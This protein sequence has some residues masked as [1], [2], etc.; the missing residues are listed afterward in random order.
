MERGGGIHNRA[1][2]EQVEADGLAGA[3]TVPSR[4]ASALQSRPDDATGYKAQGGGPC[5]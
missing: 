4:L 1:G 3:R 2:I 5:Y